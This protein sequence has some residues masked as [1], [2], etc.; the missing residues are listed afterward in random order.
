VVS[1][2][3][4]AF[5]CVTQN[6]RD[7]VL[8]VRKIGQQLNIEGRFVHA[9]RHPG[10]D[11]RHRNV[12]RR[13]LDIDRS[14]ERRNFDGQLLCNARQG[15]SQHHEETHKRSALHHSDPCSGV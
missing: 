12:H 8:H 11:A 2:A 3:I 10:D 7:V 6:H 4:L 15:E 1:A 9:E 13:I 5:E 14:F